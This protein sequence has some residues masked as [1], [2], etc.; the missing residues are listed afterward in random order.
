LSE[1]KRKRRRKGKDSR[2]RRV[3]RLEVRVAFDRNAI[4]TP[5]LGEPI[6][7]EAKKLIEKKF[8]KVAVLWFIP[9]T[10]RLEW[11]FQ[12]RKRVA[13]LV[14]H[15]GEIQR[16]TGT[17]LNLTRD[18]VESLADGVVAQTIE[19]LKLT[20]V[21]LRHERVDWPRLAED[22]P[23]RRPPFKDA[24]HE[25]GFRD[26][27]IAEQFVQL[28]EDSSVDPALCRVVFVSQDGYLV[29][30]LAK[31]IGDRGNVRIIGR[32]EE[33]ESFINALESDLAESAAEAYLSAAEKLFFDPANPSCLFLKER[34]SERISSLY[35]SDLAAVPE[36]ASERR[37]APPVVRSPRYVGREG[38]LLKWTST[39]EIRGAL[40]RFMS[41]P[42]TLRFPFGQPIVAQVMP[43]HGSHSSQ[44]SPSSHAHPAPV[45]DS[46]WGSVASAPASTHFAGS[47]LGF[48]ASTNLYQPSLIAGSSSPWDST[49]FVFGKAGYPVADA[50]SVEV[51]RVRAEFVV[52]WSTHLAGEKLQSPKMVS[53]KP[54]KPATE[55][56]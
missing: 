32:W 43:L 36:G 33:V 10:V 12:L 47:T 38:G 29:D 4:F 31:R 2:P 20:E 39:I 56:F 14:G 49:T 17:R 1:E 23:M 54:A 35:E 8:Q 51:G 3:K 41:R 46:R 18:K 25:E 19:R 37:N 45:Y 42:A 53:I 30:Y 27:L 55:F 44:P 6:S 34:I 21:G 48:Q 28:V 22:A 13:P 7:F 24:A 16:L 40:F 5:S 9:R 50:V 26:R 52:E 11:Q 15:A